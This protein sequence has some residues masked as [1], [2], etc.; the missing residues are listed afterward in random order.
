[1]ILYKTHSPHNTVSAP[2]LLQ[3]TKKSIKISLKNTLENGGR[4]KSILF[5]DYDKSAPDKRALLPLFTG[6]T[7]H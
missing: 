5:G 6:G 1:M 7:A 2:N 3:P 4:I